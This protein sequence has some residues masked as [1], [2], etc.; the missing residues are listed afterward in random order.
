MFKSEGNFKGKVIETMLADP[1]F[2]KNDPDAFD[3]CLL[4]KGPDVGGQPQEGWWRGEISGRYGAG[5]LSNKK[6]IDITMDEL[7]KVGFEG[8]DLTQLNDQLLGKEIEFFVA[9]REYEG[10]K[11]Y[12]PKY[13]GGGG[14]TPV[15][16][17][18]ES[19]AAKMARIRGGASAPAPAKSSDAD[20]TETDESGLW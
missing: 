14:A 9:G 3:V 13:L 12:D 4:L 1:K 6:Q 19:I 5:N 16:I 10:K 17:A 15:A 7:R 18:P 20:D 8:D 2:A 11:Y